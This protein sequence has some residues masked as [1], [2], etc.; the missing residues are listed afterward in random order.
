MLAA[1][2]VTV[3]RLIGGYWPDIY[4]LCNLRTPLTSDPL[5]LGLSQHPNPSEWRRMMTT[6]SKNM[7]VTVADRAR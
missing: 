5:Q 4:R 1:R 3:R 2:E 6:E 7:H